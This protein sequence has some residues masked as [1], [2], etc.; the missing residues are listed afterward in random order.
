M[1]RILFIFVQ[2]GKIIGQLFGL[3]ITHRGKSAVQ[4]IIITHTSG[5]TDTLQ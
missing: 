3:F 1:I 5:D 2:I 4:I